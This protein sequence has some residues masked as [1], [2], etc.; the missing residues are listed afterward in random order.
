MIR[1]LKEKGFTP[2]AH[3]QPQTGW[4]EKIIPSAPQDDRTPPITFGSKMPD[5]PREQ[6]M[7]LLN[8]FRQR[9]GKT[10]PGMALRMQLDDQMIGTPGGTTITTA[11]WL[12]GGQCGRNASSRKPRR[13]RLRLK[14]NKPRKWTKR[15]ARQP[16]P[17]PRT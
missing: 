17:W 8:E 15:A 3:P 16:Q 7:Q 9:M 4:M 6:Q 12:R 10:D 11:P 2:A 5:V 1:F 13:P 14:P